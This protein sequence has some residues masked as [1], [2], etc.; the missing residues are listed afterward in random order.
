MNEPSDE[1]LMSLVLAGRLQALESIY[2]RYERPLMS[3]LLRHTGSV[4]TAE[5]LLHE[6]F[7]RVLRYRSSYDVTRRFRSWMFRIAHNVAVDAADA[8]AAERAAG[9]AQGRPAGDGRDGGPEWAEAPDPLE[10]IEAGRKAV[11]VRRALGRLSE[12]DRRVLMLAKV[13]ELRYA[14]VA[15][16][17][18]CTEGA[19]KVRVHRALKRLAAQLD[20]SAD[21]SEGGST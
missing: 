17:M 4:A 16:I 10:T 1:E 13:D 14:D 15:E 9:E 21:G 6:V 12:S 11:R 19:V 8:L 2:D 5:D 18:G 7:L 20:S 3:F